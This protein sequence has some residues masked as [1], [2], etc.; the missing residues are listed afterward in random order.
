MYNTDRPIDNV[1]ND[2][3]RRASFS[4]QLAKALYYYSGDDSLVVGLFG[5]W[6]SGKTSVINMALQTMDEMNYD[7]EEKPIIVKF[8][9]WNYSSQDNLILQFFKC[10]ETKIDLVD[11]KEIREKIGKALSDYSNAF[12]AMSLIPGIGVGLAAIAKTTANAVGNSMAKKPDIE[13]AKKA[14]EK[15]LNEFDRK[16]IVVIDDIDRLSNTQIRDI[17]QLVKQVADLPKM[18][19]I[20]SMDRDVVTRAL[21]DVQHFDGNEYLEKIIQVPFVVPEVSN[22]KLHQVFFNSLDRFLLKT[23]S[24]I[25]FDQR[26][27][28]KVF[29]N[30]IKPYLRTIRDVNRVLNVFQFRWGALSNEICFE[31]LVAI[32]VID[33]LNPHVYRWISENKEAV[34]GS[35]IHS[36]LMGHKKPEEIRSRYVNELLSIGIENTD[37][38]L[39]SIAALFP[40]FAKDINENSFGYYEDTSCHR[41]KMR[42]A[43]SERYDL[44]FLLDMDRLPV[45]RKIVQDFI[46]IYDEKDADKIINELND[47]ERMPF[48]ISELI[49]LTD[50]VP[51]DRIPILINVL[52]KNRMKLVGE[53]IIVFATST[54]MR[55]EYCIE[56]LLLRLN[57]TKERFD[58]LLDQVET[59][60]LE[61]FSS[62][63]SEINHI[64]LTHGRL[65][66]KSENAS[67]QIIE[68]EQLEKLEKAF[69]KNI[70]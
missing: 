68:L 65:A 50:S 7:N 19:Y 39:K 10:I 59:D 24:D 46:S 3:L 67:E 70:I 48:F 53:E 63:C 17:F 35:P 28:T 22:S 69:C 29:E 47:T 26:Y 44:F 51:Y 5:K 49:A 58:I 1:K 52:F 9:P 14:L 27:W 64:E 11:N 42:V 36:I 15:A 8:A 4:K 32:T 20:L 66:A 6:G 21:N 13:C 55:A 41:S 37:D 18:I 2:L 54:S 23:D 62:V 31:D 33:V 25:K 16:I 40:V 60:S 45:S 56:K 38:A 34:C 30:C 57:T 61:V 43:Q 12:D